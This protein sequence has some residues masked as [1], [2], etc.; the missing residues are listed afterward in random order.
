[1]SSTKQR[2]GI[3][4]TNKQQDGIMSS[5]KDRILY[6]SLK[7]FSEKGFNGVSM[8]EI[9]SKVNIKA[10]SLYTH[11]KGKDAIYEA[12]RDV[13]AKRYQEE[14]TKLSISGINPEED[15][16]L[17]KDISLE[18]LTVIGK[19]LF[20]Y[21]I[22]DE[23]TK[24]YRK[25]VTLGQFENKVLAHEY[26]FQYFDGAIEY[27]K[28]LFGMLGISE[29]FDYEIMAIHFYA[30]IYT[31]MTICD[32]EPERE[33]EIMNLLERHIKQFLALYIMK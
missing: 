15:A 18:Q 28:K 7:L 12:I 31:F 14:V 10:A 9:A 21:F 13:M 20:Q 11:F 19:E 32:R 23:Y 8:R 25:M 5:T 1:M 16:T 17:Y 2:A 3:V 33:A 26:S 29:N 24:M 30:P 6:E 27:Q 4:R 22:H